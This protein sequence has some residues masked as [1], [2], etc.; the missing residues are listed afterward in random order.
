MG[1]TD[2]LFYVMFHDMF[3]MSYSDK[4]DDDIFFEFRLH[5]ILFSNELDSL[6]L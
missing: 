2:N 5:F 3:L 6:L 4:I 1:I